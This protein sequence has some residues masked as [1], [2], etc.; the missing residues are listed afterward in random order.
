MTDSKDKYRFNFRDLEKLDVKN[1][2][3]IEYEPLKTDKNFFN[4]L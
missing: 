2:S 4:W 1:L 3:G